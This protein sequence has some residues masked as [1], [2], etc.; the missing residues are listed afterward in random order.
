[1]IVLPS[2]TDVEFARQRCY[3]LSIAKLVLGI[4]LAV[5]F[6]AAF[7]W[8]IIF[9]G[10]CISTG[11]SGVSHLRSLDA[12]YTNDC[13]CVA[14]SALANLHHIA[15]VNTAVGIT[16]AVSSML[17]MFYYSGSTKGFATA[18]LVL[19]ICLTVAEISFVASMNVL[20]ELVSFD[21]SSGGHSAM[22]TTRHVQVAPETYTSTTGPG[23]ASNFTPYGQPR[24]FASVE[25]ETVVVGVPIQQQQQQ[26][27]PVAQYPP[28][29]QYP[30]APS[31]PT[32]AT[33]LGYSQ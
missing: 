22:A 13:C 29:P 8:V 33:T 1:M 4:G 18:S 11:L 6:W 24:N 27:Q 32:Q 9:V 14:S 21:T 20:R 28:Y 16:S 5:C 10:V 31:Y 3:A 2:T 17:A 23:Y 26:Q 7:G 15:M 12:M 30:P 25:Y 19:C